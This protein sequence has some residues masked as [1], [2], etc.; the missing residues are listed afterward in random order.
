MVI[1]PAQQTQLLVRI[2]SALVVSAYQAYCSLGSAGIL[3]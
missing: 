3:G 1:G 2:G